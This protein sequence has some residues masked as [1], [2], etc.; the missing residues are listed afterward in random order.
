MES[1]WG[2]CCRTIQTRLQPF[3][4]VEYSRVGLGET[5]A[6]STGSDNN[7]VLKEEHLIDIDIVFFSFCHFPKVWRC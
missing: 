3:V 5:S 2:G 6:T 1:S 7:E 4:H